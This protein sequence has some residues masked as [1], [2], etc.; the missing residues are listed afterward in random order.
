ME[1]K[2]EKNKKIDEKY[3]KKKKGGKNF[4]KKKRYLKKR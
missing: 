1:I 4:R 3:M 2:N